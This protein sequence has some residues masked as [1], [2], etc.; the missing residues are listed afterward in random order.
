MAKGEEWEIWRKDLEDGC[1]AVGLFNLAEVPMEVTATWSDIGIDKGQYSVRDLWRHE[2]LGVS[3]EKI[4][5]TVGRH[6]V[7]LI[8]LKP[9]FF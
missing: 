2:D 1:T 5:A 6:G 3:E 9:E 8:R 4:R 7:H